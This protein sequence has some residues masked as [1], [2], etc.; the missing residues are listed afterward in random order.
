MIPYKVERRADGWVVLDP[1]GT[2]C[3]APF[4]QKR[5]AEDWRDAA[6]REANRRAKCGPRPCLRCGQTFKSEGI[7]NRMCDGCR[8]AARSLG[9]DMAG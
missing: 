7:H 4:G 6:Q 1:R 2:P 9:R 5:F 8:A 3:S